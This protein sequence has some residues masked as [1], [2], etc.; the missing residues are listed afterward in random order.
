MR[1]LLFLARQ[2]RE[3]SYNNKSNGKQ[4]LHGGKLSGGGAQRED[5]EEKQRQDG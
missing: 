4:R 3:G 1:L 2:H 5:A